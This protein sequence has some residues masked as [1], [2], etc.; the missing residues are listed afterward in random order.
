MMVLM[1]INVILEA[2]TR[3]G[4]RRLEA[5]GNEFSIFKKIKLN[6]K[7]WLIGIESIKNRSTMLINING[8]KDF[9][10]KFQ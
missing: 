9:A 4:K 5:D 1:Q 8:D 7:E 3:N 2:K 10:V 6:N